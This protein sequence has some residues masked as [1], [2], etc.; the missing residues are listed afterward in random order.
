MKKIG[1]AQI[2]EIGLNDEHD[3]GIYNISGV[4]Y[5]ILG[6]EFT[7][8]GVRNYLRPYDKAKDKLHDREYACSKRDVVYYMDSRNTAMLLDVVK[9]LRYD[10][11]R[12]KW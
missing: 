6:G 9:D 2:S 5:I 12:Q 11:N 4:D 10:M 1:Y 3:I 7:A 8:S